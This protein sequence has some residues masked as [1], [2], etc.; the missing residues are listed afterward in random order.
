MH[1]ATLKSDRLRR[2]LKALRKRPMTTRELIQTAKVCAVNSI[3]SELRANGKEIDCWRIS[4]RTYE[5]SLR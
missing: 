3:I 2:V 1:H 5:Y 4:K